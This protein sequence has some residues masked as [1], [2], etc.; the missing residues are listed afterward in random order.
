M[1]PGV[2]RSAWTMFTRVAM[3]G[4]AYMRAVVSVPETL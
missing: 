4:Q 2:L 3:F 1:K